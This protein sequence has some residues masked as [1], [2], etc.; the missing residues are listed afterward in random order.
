MTI[1]KLVWFYLWLPWRQHWDEP[2][3][4]EVRRRMRALR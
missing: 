4:S 2:K 3:V 1:L